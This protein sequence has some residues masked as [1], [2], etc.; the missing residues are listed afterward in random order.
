M[1]T[2]CLGFQGFSFLSIHKGL[3]WAQHGR[4]HRTFLQN[5]PFS[6]KKI[7]IRRGK[8]CSS[9]KSSCTFHFIFMKNVIQ[10]NVSSWIRLMQWDVSP[11]ASITPTT[12]WLLSTKHGVNFTPQEWWHH[13][14]GLLLAIPAA[15]HNNRSMMFY[16]VFPSLT[17][18]AF[19]RHTF[20]VFEQREHTHAKERQESW[21][22]CSRRCCWIIM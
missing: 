19:L 16:L 6:N 14:D 5:A 8:K 1:F 18:G 4:G 22:E 12:V 10:I 9:S 2:L 13:G 11:A 15:G 3:I 21:E 17:V 7:R 20:L